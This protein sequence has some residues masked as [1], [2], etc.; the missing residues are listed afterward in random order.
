MQIM[1]EYLR[2]RNSTSNEECGQGQADGLI[3]PTM[4]SGTTAESMTDNIRK[5]ML[6]QKSHTLAVSRPSTPSLFSQGPDM[7]EMPLYLLNDSQPESHTQQG[8]L[9]RTTPPYGSLP[10][11]APGFGGYSPDIPGYFPNSASSE[12]TWPF[13]SPDLEA[14]TNGTPSHAAHHDWNQYYIG[15]L[16]MTKEEIENNVISRFQD[17]T[18]RKPI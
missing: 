18:C 1:K 12:S 15:G 9:P 17:R 2:R 13:Q 6:A 11:S 10:G 7:A 4:S 5:S 16:C 8:P 14:V 3:Q